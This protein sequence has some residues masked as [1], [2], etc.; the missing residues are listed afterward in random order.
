MVALALASILLSLAVPSFRNLMRSNQLLAKADALV[1]ALS[2]ARSEAAKRNLQ[3]S[4]CKSTDLLNCNPLGA[5]Q[6]GWIVYV[7]A[8]A[9]GNRDAGEVLVKKYPAFTAGYTIAASPNFQ[10]GLAYLPTGVLFSGGIV[11]DGFRFCGP[12]QNITQGRTILVN[13]VGRP[14]A[15]E[16]VTAC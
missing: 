16:G 12:D 14:R 13:A 3:V 4:L 8:N 10:N 7:D 1:G 11:A 5:W 9:D 15:S 6:Q 2:L